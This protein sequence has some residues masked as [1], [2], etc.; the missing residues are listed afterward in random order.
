MGH[1]LDTLRR[2]YERTTPEEKRR[3]I[4]QVIHE[5][6]LGQAEEGAATAATPL[7]QAMAAF[8]RLSPEDQLLLKYWL[9]SPNSPAA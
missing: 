5:V 7:E 2:V 1:S 3:P 6:V 4:E 9:D 8:E